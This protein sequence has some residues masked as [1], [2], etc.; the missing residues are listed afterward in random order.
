MKISFDYMVLK[1][2]RE[3]GVPLSTQRVGG[4]ATNSPKKPKSLQ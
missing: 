2:S 1:L 3:C 4:E